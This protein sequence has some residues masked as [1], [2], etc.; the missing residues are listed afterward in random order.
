MF[1]LPYAKEIL[2]FMAALMGIYWF[3]LYQQIRT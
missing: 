3:L 1:V 2:A